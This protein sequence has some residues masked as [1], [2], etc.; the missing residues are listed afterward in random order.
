MIAL[1][2]GYLLLISIGVGADQVH[3]TKKDCQEKNQVG[4]T[5]K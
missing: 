1:F 3:K 5:N 4:T 2:L